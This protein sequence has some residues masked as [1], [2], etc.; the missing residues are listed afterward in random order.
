MITRASTRF[1]PSYLVNQML[2]KSE[3]IDCSQ[4][5]SNLGNELVRYQIALLL[6]VYKL[7]EEPTSDTVENWLRPLKQLVHFIAV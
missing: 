1:T 6:V 4:D 3:V 2:L 5:W 7:E